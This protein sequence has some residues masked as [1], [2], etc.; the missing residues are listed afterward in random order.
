MTEFSFDLLL[1]QAIFQQHF[2]IGKIAQDSTK[3]LNNSIKKGHVTVQ[4]FPIFSILNALSISTIDYFSLDIEG[5][6]M[7]LLANIPFDKIFIKV[8]NYINNTY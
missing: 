3:S 1:F 8:H 6:E 2:N 5:S 4:C 7:E